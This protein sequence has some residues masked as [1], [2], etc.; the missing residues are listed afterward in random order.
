MIKK[1]FVLV[2][3][4]CFLINSLVVT[5]MFINNNKLVVSPPNNEEDNITLMLEQLTEEMF[6]SYVEELVSIAQ[7][8]EEARFTGTEGCEEARNFIIQEFSNMGMNV[9]SYAWTAFGTFFP[10]NLIEF[11]SYNVEARLKGTS[12]SDKFYVISAHYDTVYNTPSADDNSAGVAAVLC[13]AKILSQYN[14]NHEIRFICW[15]GEEQ[16]LLGSNAYA[17]EKYENNDN[18]IAT[19]NLDM[20][21]FTSDEI[22]NDENKV[23]VYE[24]CSDRLIGTTI[25]VS[26]NPEYS[27]YLDLKVIPSE[28]DSGHK[29][30]QG[31]FCKYSHDAIFIHEYTWNDEK[32]TSGDS[33]DN[34]DINYAT[35]VA[36]L[37]MGTIATWAASPVI[38]NSPPDKP[39]SPNGLDSIKINEVHT[40]TTSALDSDDDQIYYLFDW[41]DGS[42]SKWVGPLNSG[43]I[44]HASHMWTKQGE[45][46]IRVKVK[47]EHGIQS[48]WSESPKINTLEF[49]LNQKFNFLQNLILYLLKNT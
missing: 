25:D 7:K 1:L 31:S 33:I 19:I 24:T 20:I 36:R 4:F 40:F 32:D 46:K 29:S 28:D 30:D 5:G 49:V 23:M 3:I 44:A 48:G 12:N 2:V 34:I 42:N 21:G 17:Y 13:A 18:L 16:G 11:S 6:L 41:G 38:S 10:Y 27:S 8:Y 39:H 26:E 45:Y 9:R 37:S 22:E 43:E 14:F 47:D 35:R 15:S